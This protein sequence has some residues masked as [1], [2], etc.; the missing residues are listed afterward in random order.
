MSESF[1]LSEKPELL[2]KAEL[3]D[4]HIMIVK[5]IFDQ[6]KEIIDSYYDETDFHLKT[7]ESIQKTDVHAYINHF[8]YIQNDSVALEFYYGLPSYLWTKYGKI[9]LNKGD[10]W[11]SQHNKLVGLANEIVNKFNCTEIIPKI[12]NFDGEYGPVY[13]INK[14]NDFELENIIIERVKSNYDEDY[15]ERKENTIKF[16]SCFI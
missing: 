7:V 14:V 13:Q 2:E 11:Y 6:C 9:R 5:T 12:K 8:S 4:N 16:K 10:C 1:E 3:I 15:N